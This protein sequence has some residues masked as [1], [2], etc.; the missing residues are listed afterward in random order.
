MPSPFPG[1]NPY[2][3]RGSV[4]RTFHQN[5]I[6]AAQ[7]ALVAQVRP[8][9]IVQI[10]STL[11]IHEP[12]AEERRLLGSSDLGITS[13][14][15]SKSP[16]STHSATAA[17][18]YGSFPTG[19]E[20]EEVDRI[21]IRDRSGNSL[22]TVIELLSPTNKYAGPDQEQYLGKRRQVLHSRTHFVELDLLRSGPKLPLKGL[23]HCDYYALVSRVEE[24]PNVGVWPWKLRDPLPI[25]PIPLS[26]TDPDA[27]LDLRAALDRVYDE[28]GYSDY[29]YSGQPEPR[30]APDDAAWAAQFLPASTS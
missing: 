21:E 17:P 18:I 24:R 29:I 30:L 25:I 28:Q 10:E 16:S 19:V 8:R 6:Y 1:M 14:I 2:L 4:W 15:P 5:F 11:Y 27:R 3:E 20:I 23:P 22:L 9:Y 7:A 26:G 12:S 13:G